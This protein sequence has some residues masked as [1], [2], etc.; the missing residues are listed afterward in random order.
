MKTNWQTKK[1]GEVCE[2][3]TGGT[4]KTSVKDFYG[5]EF[6]WAGPSDLGQ[7]I[8]VTNT[9][10]KLSEK[11]FRKSG[12][13]IIPKDSVMM[14]CIGYIGKVGIA[15]EEMATNQQINT[16][17]PNNKI[18]DSK[19][20]YYVLTTKTDEFKNASSQTTLPIINK[21]KCS[22][23]E[24]LLP[25]LKTQK[26]IVAELDEKFG[27]LKE[28]KKLREDA[29]A[30]T[31]KIFSQTLREIFEEGKKKGWEEKSLDDRSILKM[32]S[33]GT[34]NRGNSK[35]YDGDIPWL[36]S[37]EL[38]DNKNIINSEEKITKE[39][40]RKS[41]AKI[42]PIGTI[43]FAMYGATAG[44]IGI[45]GIEASTNQAVVGMIPV[46]EKLNNKFLFYF[47]MK[48]REEIIAQAWGGAQ[49][50]LSQTILKTFSIPLPSLLE[51]KKIVAKLDALSEKLRTLR[52]LQNSQLDDFKS[53]ERAYLREAFKGKLI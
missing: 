48:K 52:E 31:E 47:L 44:K 50:N 34:P 4:P 20:L 9:N 8:F 41:S 32:T 16:F 30:D 14:S 53:L 2:I 15:G 18:L 11:G 42:F 51:Q 37:G 35:Y 43:L 28:A 19:Y 21:T 17:V 33:G 10:K 27:K 13:R 6:L 5:D 12:I 23:I 25:P 26:E 40:V 1:L 7:S 46:V 22:N 36:K 38:Q 45:L 39:A 29:L 24:I 49:P 3:I